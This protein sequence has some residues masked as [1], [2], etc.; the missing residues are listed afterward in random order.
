MYSGCEWGSWFVSWQE[1]EIRHVLICSE[2]M[3]KN[4][5]NEKLAAPVEPMSHSLP[6]LS[7]HRIALIKT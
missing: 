4:V 6:I 1:E 7:Q 5:V 2:N 3:K